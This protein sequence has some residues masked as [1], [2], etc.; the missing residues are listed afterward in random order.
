MTSCFDGH[1]AGLGQLAVAAGLPGHVDDHAARLHALHR[2]RRHQP[3]RGTARHE[4]RRD[5]DVEALDRVR[6]RVLL[7]GLLLVG[8]LARVAALAGGLDAEIQPGAPSDSTC[9]AVSGRTS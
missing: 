5:H 9:S 2:G 3:R 4:R 6:Q 8:Q 1:L 7:L